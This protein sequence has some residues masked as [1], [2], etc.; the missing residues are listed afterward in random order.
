MTDASPL[1]D[2]SEA[3]Q[4]LHVS[5]QTM[6]R[7]VRRGTVPHTRVGNSIRVARADLAAYLEGGRSHAWH[8]EHG[9]G[10]PAGSPGA[11]TAADRLRAFTKPLRWSVSA[12]RVLLDVGESATWKR[13]LLELEIR[14]RQL[15]ADRKVTGRVITGRPPHQVTLEI[16][17]GRCGRSASS[18]A[19]PASAC[20]PWSRSGS[21]PARDNTIAAGLSFARRLRRLVDFGELLHR[22]PVQL[23]LS[24]ADERYL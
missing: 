12:G 3:A 23:Q 11:P 18:P 19:R 6:Y 5:R 8:P 2:I 1:L 14:M 21:G 22:F 13:A 7:I 20:R 24:P 17:L 16:P 9:R 4:E 15:G 10:R